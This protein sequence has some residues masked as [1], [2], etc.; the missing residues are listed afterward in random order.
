ML[1]HAPESLDPIDEVLDGR[2]VDTDE[3]P[4]VGE[5][6]PGRAGGSRRAR[7]RL[8]DLDLLLD[9]GRAGAQITLMDVTDGTS[10][11]LDRSTWR[12]DAMFP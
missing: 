6:E 7:L 5:P 8:D 11:Q 1:T 3:G 2:T 9:A 4:Q 10:V 12:W